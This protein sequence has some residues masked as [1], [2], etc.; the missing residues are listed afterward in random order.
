[1]GFKAPVNPN[2]PVAPTRVYPPC[3]KCGCKE[4]FIRSGLGNKFCKKCIKHAV[5]DHQSRKAK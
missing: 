3:H 2:H 5:A 1:M 4:A